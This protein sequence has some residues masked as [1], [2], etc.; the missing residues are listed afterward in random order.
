MKC[1]VDGS[2]AMVL[3]RLV[4][5]DVPRARDSSPAFKFSR[6]IYLTELGARVPASIY[7]GERLAPGMRLAGPAVVERMGDTIL[8]PS[9]ATAAVDGFGNV[10]LALDISQRNY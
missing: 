6:D 2:A 4:A 10:V 8:L 7:D 5:E 9:F 1:R 3:P